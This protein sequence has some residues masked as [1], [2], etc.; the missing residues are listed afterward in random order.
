MKGESLC[1]EMRTILRWCRGVRIVRLEANAQQY[2]RHVL[3]LTGSD[4]F[5]QQSAHSSVGNLDGFLVT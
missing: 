4:M 2:I 5:A 1:K 3:F